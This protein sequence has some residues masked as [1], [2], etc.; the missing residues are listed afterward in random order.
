MEHL[1]AGRRYKWT[2]RGMADGMR[3]QGVSSY[4]ALR[5]IALADERKTR[6]QENSTRSG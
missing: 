3:A 1:L 2:L 5:H 4:D 6:G